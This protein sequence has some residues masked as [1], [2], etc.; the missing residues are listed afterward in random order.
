MRVDAVLFDMDETLINLTATRPMRLRRALE[1]L[2]ELTGA[3][4]DI[5]GALVRAEELP[6]YT[7]RLKI[8][9]GELGH[10][11]CDYGRQAYEVIFDASLMELHDGAEDLLLELATNYKLGLVTNGP[12][13]TQTPKIER[14]KLLGHFGGAVAIGDDFGHPKPD[15]TIFLHVAAV[16]GVEPAHT[17]FVGDRLDAD[18]EGAKRAGMIAVWLHT[19]DQPDYEGPPPDFE[20]RRITELRQ[21]LGDLG[22][23]LMVSRGQAE[24]VS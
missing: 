15:P 8:L 21:V 10:A 14:F 13:R 9:L 23:P 2:N 17:M 4:C 7:D 24:P 22:E 12:G 3:D 16:L 18:I 6:V 11:D 20:I 5:E 1:K 19:V